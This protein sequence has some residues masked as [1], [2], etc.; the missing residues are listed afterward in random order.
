MMPLYLQAFENFKK[1]GIDLLGDYRN[2]FP[3]KLLYWVDGGFKQSTLDFYQDQEVRT[4]IYDV[5]QGMLNKY[6]LLVT[7]TLACLPVDNAKDG[8]V[9]ALPRLMEYPS[10]PC[11]DGY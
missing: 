11:S 9:S 7:P 8:T 1:S 5:I 3:S 6:D 4:E 2:D 10:S